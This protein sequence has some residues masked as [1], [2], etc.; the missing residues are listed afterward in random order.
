MGVAG[1]GVP[2]TS[3]FSA[4]PNP[5][6]FPRG[7]GSRAGPGKSGW[8]GV[9]RPQTQHASALLRPPD[10]KAFWVHRGWP[11]Q[12]GAWLEFGPHSPLR[13]PRRRSLGK[14]WGEGARRVLREVRHLPQCQDP[15]P[16]VCLQELQMPLSQRQQRLLEP[17]LN[18]LLQQ[19]FAR[20]FFSLFPQWSVSR[21]ERSNLQFAQHLEG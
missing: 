18:T 21:V 13:P 12:S 15:P 9:W 19:L 5:V 2:G 17:G 1:P 7:V 3:P 8:R 10:N 16:D 4:A 14:P 6:V 11:T 20:E